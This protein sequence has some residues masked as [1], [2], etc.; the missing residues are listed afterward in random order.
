MAAG[1]SRC[2]EPEWRRSGAGGGECPRPG[3]LTL[4]LADIRKSR[5]GNSRLV[6]VT[7]RRGNA[8][9][10]RRRGAIATG[11]EFTAALLMDDRRG[12]PVP[13]RRARMP[14]VARRRLR[15]AL[16]PAV[17]PVVV[18]VRPA[19]VV[20]LARREAASA[21][22]GVAAVPPGAVSRGRRPRAPSVHAAGR[23]AA[24][25]TRARSGASRHVR[26]LV[27]RLGRAAGREIVARRR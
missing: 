16:V 4:K 17:A 13:P 20:A 23:A 9:A 3:D 12:A 18:A 24:A 1:T 25:P 2:G 10:L 14:R 8:I 7:R 6:M 19:L 26:V 22:R 27:R 15:A 11:R 5:S 21:R